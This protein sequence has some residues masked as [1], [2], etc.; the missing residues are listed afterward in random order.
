MKNI[1]VLIKSIMDI[2]FSFTALIFLLIPFLVI[3]III[4][5]TSK[6]PVFFTQKRVG[7]NKKIYTIHKF[8]TMRV[9]APSDSP[10]HML[11]NPDEY[12][13]NIGRFLRR[14]SIDELPNIIDIIRGK[15]S[16]IGPRPALYNQ[17]DLIQERDKYNANNLKPGITGWA[18]VNG[19]D[20]LPIPIK[21]ALDGEYVNK[22][23]LSLDIKIIFKTILKVL[24]SE[25]V[26]EGA[27]G[28]NAIVADNKDINN[29]TIEND[30][31]VTENIKNDINAAE[32]IKDDT[33]VI[34]NIKSATEN[35]LENNDNTSINQ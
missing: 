12:I 11:A 29:S 25:G 16:F 33:N 1:Y 22:I 18:Q 7:K 2:V 32:N 28:D 31:N 15:M 21:A 23:S 30:I 17:E 4:K 8:R 6:G 27:A 9:D 26:R 34:D 35:N 20:E 13:T 3:A 14:T 5:A 10:T 24:K 19:R